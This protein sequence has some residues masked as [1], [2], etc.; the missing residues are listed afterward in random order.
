MGMDG[1]VHHTD[2]NGSALESD[3]I[4]LTGVDLAQLSALPETVFARSL[5]RILAEQDGTA[6]WDRYASFENVISSEVEE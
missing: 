1:D 6:G 5:R 3:L 2:G 4:D